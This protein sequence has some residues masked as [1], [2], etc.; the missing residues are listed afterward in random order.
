[1]TRINALL[2]T[3]FEVCRENWRMYRWRIYRSECPGCKGKYFISLQPNDLMTRCMSCWATAM[4]L[5]LIPV[6]KDH[7]RAQKIESVWEMSTYGATL[8]YLKK[9]CQ[10][11]YQSEFFP[12]VPSG[13]LVDGVLCQDVQNL[14]FA[15]E[16]LDLITSNQVFEHVANDLQG[17]AECH[18][19]LR[20]GGALVLGVPLHD[21]P[22]TKQLAEL[23]DGKLVFYGEPE[24][25]GSRVT[26]PRSVPTFWHYSVHDIC[27]RISS[28]GFE[29]QIL[30]TT[31]SG[32]RVISSPVVFAVKH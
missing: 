26:G 9:T 14:S 25:H 5:S 20:K 21:I 27:E 24:Y 19:V 17:F 28:V 18:R 11:V 16:S 1:M 3:A 6:V 7:S 23:S 12:G 2:K 4:N 15:G 31:L 32:S 10:S 8:T 29:V 13:Q 22:N 30:K